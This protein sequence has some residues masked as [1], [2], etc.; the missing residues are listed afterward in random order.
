MLGACFARQ[1]YRYATGQVEGPQQDLGFLVGATGPDAKMTD[2][3]LAIIAD[4]VFSNRTF[5]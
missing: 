2:A 4:R 3:L 5:E 1:V